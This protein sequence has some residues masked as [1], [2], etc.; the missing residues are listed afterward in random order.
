M[1]ED[2][3]EDNLVNFKCLERGRK[4]SQ[5]YF[6]SKLASCQQALDVIDR[7]EVEDR[8]L[9]EEVPYPGIKEQIRFCT[10][11]PLQPLYQMQAKN[12]EE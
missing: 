9:V 6:R 10:L 3:E 1:W 7:Q 5:K 11:E 2:R 4:E 12:N 8:Y